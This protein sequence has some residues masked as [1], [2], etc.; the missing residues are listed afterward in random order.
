MYELK[1]S[2]AGNPDFGQHTPISPAHSIPVASIEEATERCRDYI[3]A[4]NLG[5][6]NWSGG[7]VYKGD[8]QVAR[9]AYNG[10]VTYPIINGQGKTVWVTVPGGDDAN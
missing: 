9:I 2:S 7:Q 1:L 3:R 8:K 10:R 6:G 5:G 4:W